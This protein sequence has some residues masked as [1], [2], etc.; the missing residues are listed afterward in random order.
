MIR[1]T[2]DFRLAAR[3]MG[4]VGK[5]DANHLFSACTPTLLAHDATMSRVLQTAQIGTSIPT[6]FLRPIWHR[7]RF[8]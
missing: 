7:C 2:K 6:G 5:A 3:H 4:R 8:F 1:F